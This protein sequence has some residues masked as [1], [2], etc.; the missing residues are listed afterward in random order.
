MELPPD[1]R[2]CGDEE[3]RLESAD[4]TKLKASFTLP[5]RKGIPFGLI[6]IQKTYRLEKNTLSLFYTLCNRSDEKTVLHFVPRFDLSLAG[7]ALLFR[8]SQG[9]EERSVEKQ[10]EKKRVVFFEEQ[11][12]RQG[13]SIGIGFQSPC[14]LYYCPVENGSQALCFFPVF[15]LFLNPGDIWENKI[16]AAVS[17]K[18][19][20]SK[21]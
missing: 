10:G 17:A 14:D 15:Q 18:T 19:R 8:K 5:L 21:N 4:R 9:E 6:E 11:E 16:T 12:S 13:A 20:S 3:Y 7:E 2:I 1:S